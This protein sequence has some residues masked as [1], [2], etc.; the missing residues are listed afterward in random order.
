[1]SSSDMYSFDSRLVV[2]QY[3]KA[4][5]TVLRIRFSPCIIEQWCP[6]PLARL[7][8][9]RA[10][11]GYN[12]VGQANEHRFRTKLTESSEKCS[13]LHKSLDLHQSQWLMRNQ[14]IAMQTNTELTETMMTELQILAVSANGVGGGRGGWASYQ[15]GNTI[16]ANNRRQQFLKERKSRDMLSR[17]DLSWNAAAT[18][19]MVT[20]RCVF[21]PSI[22]S[23]YSP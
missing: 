2:W 8:Q 10:G 5:A 22:N 4:K 18:K 20:P 21:C 7:S 14:I 9:A 11:S 12:I 16:P 17:A 23:N 1:M 3:D 6:G 19:N 15:T 13:L